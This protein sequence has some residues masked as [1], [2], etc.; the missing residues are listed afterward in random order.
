MTQDSDPP[1]GLDRTLWLRLAAGGATY[2]IAAL[3]L[4][5]FGAIDGIAKL[6]LTVA[7]I[8]A[9]ILAAL[10]SL[11]VLARA[12]FV[13]Q[14]SRAWAALLLECLCLMLFVCSIDTLLG[15]AME[16]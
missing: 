9:S 8:P 15:C 16:P 6:A 10:M 1:R 5:Q 13:G 12:T 7:S 3:A 14:R 11:L 2:S 4:V